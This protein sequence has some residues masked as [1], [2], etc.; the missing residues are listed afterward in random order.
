MY[1][2]MICMHTYVVLQVTDHVSSKMLAI[3][4]KG[5][6]LSETTGT[7]QDLV[8]EMGMFSSASLQASPP[9]ELT[10]SQQAFPVD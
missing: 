5:A 7:V 4:S 10:L 6:H 8:Q 9:D 1:M 3:D 2:K